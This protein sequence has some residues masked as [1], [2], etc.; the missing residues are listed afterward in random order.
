VHFLC[1]RSR[2]LPGAAGGRAYWTFV[3]LIIRGNTVHY[4][5]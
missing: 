1:N 5:R 2:F 3:R 4:A